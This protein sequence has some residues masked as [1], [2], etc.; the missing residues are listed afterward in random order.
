MKKLETAFYH[1]TSV[2]IILIT[3]SLL[4]TL[5][6][7]AWAA[8]QTFD[9]KDPKGVNNVAFNVDAPLEAVNGTANGVSGLVIYDPENPEAAK[10]KIAV[11]TASLTVPNPM[12]TGHMRGEKW[13]DAEHFPEITFEVKE[14]QNAKRDGDN[15]AADAVGTFTLKGI[16]KELT[17]PVKLTY[18]KGRLGARLPGKKGD[19]L[20]IRAQFAINRSDF[21]IQP[22]QNEAA[23]SDKIGLTLALAGASP[24]GE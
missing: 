24:T 21:N 5:A 15:L 2:K 9:F 7:P 10:G 18:L 12:Q 22:H 4:G 13:L 23:V 3:L 8:P 17:V 11:T 14:L 16:S 6:V 20:I 1:S 19:L